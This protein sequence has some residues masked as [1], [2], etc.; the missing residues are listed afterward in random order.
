LFEKYSTK[1][2]DSYEKK[3]LITLAYYQGVLGRIDQ[4]SILVG[5]ILG[6]KD[7]LKDLQNYDLSKSNFFK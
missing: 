1:T 3:D 7:G 2:I 4:M 6:F 5:Y